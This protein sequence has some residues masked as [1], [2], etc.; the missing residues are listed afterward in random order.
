MRLRALTNLSLRK[1]GDPKDPEYNEWHDWKAGATFDAPEH[2]D[3]KRAIARGIAEPA[4]GMAP[5]PELTPVAA[6]ADAPAR[7]E[8]TDG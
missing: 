5:K 3:V 4:K 6:P 7:E 1:A 2:M 8:V